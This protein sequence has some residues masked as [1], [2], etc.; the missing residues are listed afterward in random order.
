MTTLLRALTLPGPAPNFGPLS[1][2]SFVPDRNDEMAITALY[3][4]TDQNAGFQTIPCTISQPPAVFKENSCLADIPFG[5]TAFWINCLFCFGLVV[6]IYHKSYLL[7]KHQ[8][9]TRG[10]INK[11]QVF[12]A[13][14]S[15][16]TM[17]LMS[18][19][20]HRSFCRNFDPIVVM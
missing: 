5:T 17:A 9:L 4:L 10:S 11:T 13:I 20:R 7:P 15:G 12:A 16:L 19:D 6:C 18:L 3:E 8:K 1:S 2:E 14:M